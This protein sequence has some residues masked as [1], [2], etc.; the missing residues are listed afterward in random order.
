MDSCRHCSSAQETHTFSDLQACLS[1]FGLDSAFLR[2][3]PQPSLCSEALRGSI[4]P[5]I[6]S[7]RAEVLLRHDGK[8]AG[9]PGLWAFPPTRSSSWHADLGHWSLHL[10][11]CPR[12]TTPGLLGQRSLDRNH[13]VCSSSCPAWLFPGGIMFCSFPSQVS[14]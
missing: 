4:L 9:E 1:S 7:K 8:A 12:A 14:L 2:P 6:G 3:Q 5:G 13:C 10:W 11:L